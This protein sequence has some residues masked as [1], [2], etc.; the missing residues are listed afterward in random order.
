[1]VS[2]PN[3]KGG[4]VKKKSSLLSS[5]LGFFYNHTKMILGLYLS[6][7]VIAAFSWDFIRELAVYEQIRFTMNPME[8]M[9]ISISYSIFDIVKYFVPVFVAVVILKYIMVKARR[10]KLAYLLKKSL[11][12][13][14]GVS[15][16]LSLCFAII[17]Y[18][19][20]LSLAGYSNKLIESSIELFVLFFLSILFIL[21]SMYGLVKG[22]SPILKAK[23]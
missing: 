7:V 19:D 3:K 4:E 5:L 16:I 9:Y 22:V 12:K 18:V 10:V 2:N 8:I 23:K 15:F 17:F 14:I 6:V 20:V 13:Q 1:M 11:K 21:L